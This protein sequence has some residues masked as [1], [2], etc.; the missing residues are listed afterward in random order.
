MKFFKTL[1]CIMLT[2]HL[3]GCKNDRRPSFQR[4]AADA[5]RKAKHAPNDSTMFVIL[6]KF[7]KDS[8]WT[9]NRETGRKNA[10]SIAAVNSSRHAYGSLTRRDTYAVMAD[11]RTKSISR[12]INITELTGLWM[13]DDHSGNGIRID[14]TGTA[15][16]VGIMDDITL[17]SWH[18]HNGQLVFSHVKNDGTDYEETTTTVSIASL[19]TERFVFTIGKQLYECYRPQ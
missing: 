9:T 17:R 5:S 15:S 19:T 1:I 3:A 7:D 13:F 10:F 8:V 6:D 11:I 4:T 2:L 12:L 14:S 16:N 18:I